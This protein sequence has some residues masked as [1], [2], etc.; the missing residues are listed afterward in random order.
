MLRT[1]PLNRVDRR[2]GL[3]RLKAAFQHLMQGGRFVRNPKVDDQ[4]PADGAGGVNGLVQ[5]GWAQ[6]HN[7]IGLQGI[8]VALDNAGGK[9]AD[10]YVNLMELVEML[11]IRVGPVG[12]AVVVKLIEQRRVQVVDRNLVPLIVQQGVVQ[13]HWNLRMKNRYHPLYSAAQKM[14]IFLCTKAKSR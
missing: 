9:A 4:A 14:Q 6:Q 2:A 10:L 7:I 8:V 5:K 11:E 3:K 12:P 13:I 1:S